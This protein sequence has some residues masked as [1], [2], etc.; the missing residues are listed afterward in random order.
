MKVAKIRVGAK[1][2]FVEVVKVSTVKFDSRPGWVFVREVD[3]IARK[4]DVFWVHPHDT[5]FHWVRDFS[6][7]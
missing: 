3:K 4:C 1:D 6:G 2:K 5:H 7:A